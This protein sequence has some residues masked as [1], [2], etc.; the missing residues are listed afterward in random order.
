MTNPIIDALAWDVN[1]PAAS[2]R[3]LQTA[4]MA[5]QDEWNNKVPITAQVSRNA[6]VTEEDWQVY[7]TTR[8]DS[9]FL[10]FDNVSQKF[11]GLWENIFGSIQFSRSVIDSGL[12][13]FHPVNILNN[14]VS[15]TGAATTIILEPPSFIIPRSAK[16]F[17]Y[18]PF[19]INRNSGSSDI[20]LVLEI[21]SVDYLTLVVTPTTGIWAPFTLYWL[22]DEYVVPPGVQVGIILRLKATVAAAN[23]CEFADIAPLPNITGAIPLGIITPYLG[24]IEAIYS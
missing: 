22:S 17:I 9:S 8:Q 5:L 12:S 21:N 7:D 10:H 13:E 24:Y 20:T 23:V 11:A 14:R 1:N 6:L 15:I 18:L 3:A 4:L 2:V 16:L 19:L